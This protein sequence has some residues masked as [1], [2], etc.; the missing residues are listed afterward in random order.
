VSSPLPVLLSGSPVGTSNASPDATWIAMS[1]PP[2]GAAAVVFSVD[3]GTSVTMT[4]YTDTSTSQDGS[5]LATLH[6]GLAVSTGVVSA[7]V[8]TIG[9]LVRCKV[10]AV[11][12]SPT[13]VRGT[14]VPV[15][16]AP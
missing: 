2:T 8:G 14:F 1:S 6:S 9:G 12:G 3:G 10:T 11:G 13:A 5:A 16:W 4:I 7:P 15:G